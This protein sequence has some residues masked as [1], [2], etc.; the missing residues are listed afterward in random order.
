M[1]STR[2]LRLWPN[3]GTDDA[4]PVGPTPQNISVQI[5]IDTAETRAKTSQNAQLRGQELATHL[6]KRL[7]LT[8]TNNRSTMLSSN[9]VNGELR[10]RLHHIFD[11][12]PDLVWRALASYLGEDSEAIDAGQVLDRFIQE[13]SSTISRPPMRVQPVGRY[14]DLS[15]LHCELNQEYFAG[16]ST[17]RITWAKNRGPVRQKKR[18]TTIQL[19][20]YIGADNLIRIHPCLDQGFVPRFYIRWIVYHEMLHEAYGM[21]ENINGRSMVHPPAFRALESSYPD[22]QRCQQWEEA[23]IDRLIGYSG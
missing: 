17:T 23:H 2:Q 15:A 12:A 22:F 19:G 13:A 1:N 6:G 3:V 7:R 20:A 21:D 10:V 14:H 5:C 4:K 11:Q 16:G 9:E 8:F 18:R